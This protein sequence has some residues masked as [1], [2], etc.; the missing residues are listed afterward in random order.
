[1][2]RFHR[3]KTQTRDGALIFTDG[4]QSWGT[5]LAFLAGGGLVSITAV[6]AVAWLAGEQP[7]PV[8]L[9]LAGIAALALVAILGVMVMS[10]GLAP[11][12]R[13]WIDP[14]TGRVRLW[15]TEIRRKPRV[16]EVALA[17]LPAPRVYTTPSAPDTPEQPHLEI[18][19]TNS[20]W[21]SI[22]SFR[23]EEEASACAKQI[24]QLIRG[25]NGGPQPA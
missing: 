14:A 9:A 6:M 22:G 15:Q 16:T 7:E 25:A 3:A 17:D 24:V 12:K 20:D 11:A 10:I 8:A 5:R 18:S 21:I 23:T 2:P 4:P 13:L 19:L 1:M